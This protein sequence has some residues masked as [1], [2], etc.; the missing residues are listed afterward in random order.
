SLVTSKPADEVRRQVLIPLWNSYAFFV[1]Y[2]RLD[3]FDPASESIPLNQRPEIDRWILS[4]LQTL[5]EASAN[6]WPKCDSATACAEAAAFID[7]LSNWYIRRNRRRF[8]RGKS[9]GD[10]DKLAAYQTLYEVL[11]TLTR[12]LAPAIPFLSERMY[13][14]L[15]CSWDETA[16]ESVHLC[17]FP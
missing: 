14:N 4:N 12:L 6:A 10:R 3:G 8:W 16:P 9:E 11:V 17:R 2:A 13:R 5:I 15:V 7:D 1:N